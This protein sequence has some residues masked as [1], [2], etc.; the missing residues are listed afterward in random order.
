VII[1]V[2]TE[3]DLLDLDD[4]LVLAGLGG[5]FLG[6]ILKSAEVENFADRRN[7]LRSD[8]DKIKP[9]FFR[10]GKRLK[11]R[12]YAEVLAFVVNQLNLGNP[13]DL[14]VDTRPILGG[15]RRAKRSANGRCLLLGAVATGFGDGGGRRLR[16]K[17]LKLRT[18]KRRSTLSLIEAS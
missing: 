12:D 14:P 9:C 6:L 1:D 16:A 18:L 5:L 2:R 7:R 15:R 11:I 10:A 17:S 13:A 4:F 3:F 8:L